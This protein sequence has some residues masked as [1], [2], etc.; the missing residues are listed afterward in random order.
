[1]LAVNL[2]RIM[3]SDDGRRIDYDYSWSEKLNKYFSQ[4][5]LHIEFV[6]D[7]VRSVPASIAVIPFLGNVLPM[8]WFIG[9]DVHV[10]EVDE[11]YF[12]SLEAFKKGFLLS[13]KLAIDKAGSLRYR[14]LVKNK[15]GG[16]NTALLYSGGVDSRFT[17]LHVAEENPLLITVHGADF[18]SSDTEQLKI[19]EHTFSNDHLTG[20]FGRSVI[21]TN[22]RG[23]YTSRVNLLLSDCDWWG[24]VQHGIGLISVVAPLAFVYNIAR[25]YIASSNT[26]ALN[27]TW[28]SSKN[29]DEELS[30]AGMQVTHHGS[31]FSRVEKTRNIVKAAVSEHSSTLLKVCYKTTGYSLNCSKCEKCY[32]T[33]LTV[34]LCGYDPRQLG[35]DVSDTFYDDV[36]K[37]LRKGFRSHFVAYFWSEIAEELRSRKGWLVFKYVAR[38]QDQLQEIQRL[39]EKNMLRGVAEPSL[40]RRFSNQVRARFPR[41]YLGMIRLYK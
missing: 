41:L 22:M 12:H 8:A 25:L 9:F 36:A 5:R 28:G 10:E 15:I 17:L 40:I 16:V 29:Q 1:M 3:Y 32:R 27:I 35:F 14:K 34:I 23:F 39:I 30:F 13:H 20:K 24:R 18:H 33:M 26:T 4:H 19:L 7:N 38:E 21:R 2:N 6:R 11:D 37:S 31:E